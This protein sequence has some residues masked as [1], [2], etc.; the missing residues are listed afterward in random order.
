MPRIIRISVQG[1][2]SFT[3]TVSRYAGLPTRVEALL[4]TGSWE[5]RDT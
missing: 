3:A 1:R 5:V 4:Q 2:P